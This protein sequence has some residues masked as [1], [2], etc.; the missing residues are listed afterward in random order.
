VQCSFKNMF[1][2]DS[3]TYI[4]GVPALPKNLDPR[5]SKLVP[6][7][8]TLKFC[9]IICLLVHILDKYASIWSMPSLCFN[10]Y[11]VTLP[12]ISRTMKLK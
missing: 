1:C 4:H 8:D 11:M 2:E 6:R 10:G 5:R 9:I 3:H 12:C 7:N